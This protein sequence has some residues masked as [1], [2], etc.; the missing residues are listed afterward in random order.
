[1]VDTLMDS[2]DIVVHG[3]HSINICVCRRRGEFG[4]VIEVHS[5]WVKPIKTSV[6][7]EF[8]SAGGC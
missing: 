2:L 8:V 1:M 7:G 5:A 4:L 3:S 6:R